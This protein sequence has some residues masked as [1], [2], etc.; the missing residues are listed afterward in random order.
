M[1][2]TSKVSATEGSGKNVATYSLTEDAVTKEVQRVTLNDSSGAELG[3]A[4]NPMRTNPTGTTTQP[5]SVAAGTNII[6]KVA[7]DQT[8]PGTTNAVQLAA[9]IPAGSNIIGTVKTD[10]TTHGTTDL[11]A[12]DI[13]KIA[14]NVINAGNGT[15][16]SGT[17][18]VAVASDNTPFNVS[19]S[20]ETSQVFN[21]TT[22]LTPKF[23]VI[24]ASSSGATTIVSAV[25]S[26]KIRVLAMG[27]VANGA[28]NV[29]WQSH[30]TPTDKT[31]LAY[32]AANG[33]YILPYNPVGW[34]ETIAGEALDINL[35]GAVAVGGQLTYIEV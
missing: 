21:G 24:T 3:T 20:N 2:T 5:V 8:T 23:A 33:G 34:F 27:L 35:S 26:K 18:R 12:A 6:G 7:I 17:P 29:K 10:Q 13:T 28:V 4:G 22:A 11:V 30:V 31:G 32:L 15:S 9:A 16:S 25:S 1:A 14:G 19:A